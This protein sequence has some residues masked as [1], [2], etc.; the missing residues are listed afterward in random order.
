MIHIYSKLLVSI[1]SGFAIL[2]HLS[3]ASSFFFFLYQ[4]IA[5]QIKLNNRNIGRGFYLLKIIKA[6]IFFQH[7]KRE[8]LYIG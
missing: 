7:E 4:N 1:Y 2:P 3:L 5:P 8:Q 6:E